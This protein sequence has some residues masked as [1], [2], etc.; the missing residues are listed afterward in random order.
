ML[1]AG[2]CCAEAGHVP[3]PAYE[4]EPLL[5]P[6]YQIPQGVEANASSGAIALRK[7]LDP[8]LPADRRKLAELSDDDP[9]WDVTAHYLAGLCVNL[10]LI[11]SP[12]KIGKRH[13]GTPAR[14]RQA[15]RRQAGS[16]AR[17]QIRGFFAHLAPI[18]IGHISK[19]ALPAMCSVWWWRDEARVPFP[20]DSVSPAS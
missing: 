8:T 3:V 4:A 6:D 7:G 14:C 1:L 15:D 5:Q 19:L 11:A 18:R 13:E 2:P 12:E 10:I 9:V 16:L 20:K 17:A